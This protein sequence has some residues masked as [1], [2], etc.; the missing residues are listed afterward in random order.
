M[1]LS[2][3]ITNNEIQPTSEIN[4]V[5]ATIHDERG[6]QKSTAKLNTPAKVESR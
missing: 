4:V 3:P 6:S 1:D 2:T 5:H